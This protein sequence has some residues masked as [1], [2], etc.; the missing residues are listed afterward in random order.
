ME[1]L[2]E[3]LFEII[4]EGAVEIGTSRK[5]PLPLRILAFLV[6]LTIFGGIVVLLLMCGIDALWEGRK[7]AGIL[8]LVM[9]IGLFFG[10]IYMVMKK[11]KK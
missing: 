11:M 10:S 2:F 7:P 8:F 1:F 4:V 9:A 5:I 6:I 3:L